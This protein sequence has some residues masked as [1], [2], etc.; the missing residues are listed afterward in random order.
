[1]LRADKFC[2]I[3][4]FGYCLIVT[5]L[6]DFLVCRA[7][8]CLFVGGREKNKCL[9]KIKHITYNSTYEIVLFGIFL[10][11]NWA[12]ASSAH[13]L[14]TSCKQEAD[15]WLFIWLFV[16]PLMAAQQGMKYSII[17]FFPPHMCVLIQVTL[18]PC[19]I[20]IF[21]LHILHILFQ[22]AFHTV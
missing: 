18:K 5:N 10:R 12:P 4:I 16:N 15:F 9:N 19:Y 7:H 20:K 14:F 13:I 2:S 8:T 17:V 11:D 1:M 6:L 3:H 21:I 22:K